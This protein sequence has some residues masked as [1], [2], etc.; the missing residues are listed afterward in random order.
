MK[1]CPICGNR[2][3]GLGP[4]GRKSFDGVSLPRC[5]RCQSLER[6]RALR[7]FWMR[8]PKEFLIDRKV[9]QFSPD[10]SVDARWFGSYEVSVYGGENSIDI[11]HIDRPDGQYDIVIC[12]HVLEHIQ[13][14]R[15]ALREMLRIIS[16]LGFILL[17][18]PSPF[19]REKTVDWGFPKQEEHGHYRV[20]GGDIGEVL[21]DEVVGNSCYHR[22]VIEDTVT[23]SQDCVYLL[24][25][26]GVALEALK[27]FVP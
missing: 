20:Y 13:D 11:Q 25:K 12:V 24:S 6:H 15:L 26:S 4:N 16:P 18:V 27:K 2:S 17:A 19:H 5:T 23:S 14:D 3:F 21:L 1:T 9:L 10:R 8:F 22:V 7:E